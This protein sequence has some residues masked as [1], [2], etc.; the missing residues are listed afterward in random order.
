MKRRSKT[1]FG[2][3]F[4]VRGN[5]KFGGV[6]EAEP[7]LDNHY[8]LLDLS[9]LAAANLATVIRRG[10]LIHASG[11]D[12][13]VETIGKW[14]TRR[15]PW[16]SPAWRRASAT[17]RVRLW[18]RRPAGGGVVLE[19]MNQTG[20]AIGRNRHHSVQKWPGGKEFRQPSARQESDLN[21]IS[22]LNR[23]VPDRTS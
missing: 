20:I 19:E 11:K 15:N 18:R 4:K 17:S 13:A 12:P 10:C 23:E 9:S 2:I 7:A 5:R 21:F 3:D 16:V 1:S 22:S 6:D 8:R 14:I